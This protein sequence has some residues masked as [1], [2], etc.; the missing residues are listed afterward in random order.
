[1]R[2][3]ASVFAFVCLATPVVAEDDPMEVQRCI[4]R[5]LADSKGADDPAYVR[6]TER[7]CSGKPEKS[8][9]KPTRRSAKPGEWVYAEH[10]R[11]GLTAHVE[12]GGEAFGF[13]CPDPRPEPHG[14]AVATRITPGLSPGEK[15]S[16]TVVWREPFAVGG[17]LVLS[18]AAGFWEHEADYCSSDVPQ[19]K[20]HGNMLLLREK[21]VSLDFSDG[22]NRMTVEGTR[23]QSVLVAA[24]DIAKLDGPVEIPLAGS[25][26]AIASLAKACPPLRRQ[27]AEGCEID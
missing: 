25:A 1:M 16:N 22:Q 23:G 6:C 19:A 12:V 7:R 18:E 24:D 11:L 10:P 21:F 8:R 2:F 26:A 4:W 3:A 27:M 9:K 15:G 17:Q 13:A 5:C 14:Y 20:T